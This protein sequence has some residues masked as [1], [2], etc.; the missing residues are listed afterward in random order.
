MDTEIITRLKSCLER[1]IP[2]A[3]VTVISSSGHTPARIGDMMLVLPGEKIGS[4]GGGQ[5]EHFVVVEAEKLLAA[6]KSREIQ[7][8]G[9]GTGKTGSACGGNVRLFVRVFGTSPRLVIVGAGHVARELYTLGA[10]L[11]FGVVIVDDR[12]DMLA[13]DEFLG[14]ET[15]FVEQFDE[16]LKELITGNCYVAIAT[17]SHE[18]DRVA[19]EAL[20]GAD[21]RYLGLIGSSSKLRGIFGSLREKGIPGE[22]IGE[23]HAPMGLNIA[24][25]NPREIAMSIMAEILLIKNGGSPEYMRD[26]KNVGNF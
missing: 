20:I 25:R 10:Y 14:A 5:L 19:V 23:I 21:V 12:K 1:G 8:G 3:S 17:R 7:H 22:R 11:G 13:A 9:D 16:N 26:V 6:G 4:V 24:S 15:V 18:T 2:A